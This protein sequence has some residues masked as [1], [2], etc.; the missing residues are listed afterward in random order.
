MGV[1]AKGLSMLIAY[2]VIGIIVCFFAVTAGLHEDDSGATVAAC[3]IATPIF[4]FGWPIFVLIVICHMVARR[5][6]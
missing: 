2:F 1:A 4:I 3:V 6:R 5:M